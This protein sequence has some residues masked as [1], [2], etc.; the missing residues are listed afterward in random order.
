MAVDSKR[1][2]KNT[3]VLYLRMIITLMVGLF[4][5][6][7]TLQTLGISDYVVYNVVGGFV[8]IL[9]YIN[10]VFIDADQR[11]ITF[12]LGEGNKD[13]LKRVFSTSV[14]TQVVYVVILIIVSE[15][16]GLWFVNHKLVI[17]PERIVAANWVYHCSIGSLLLTVL[18]I[19]YRACIVAHERMGIYAYISIVEIILKLV[20]VYLLVVIPA[21][22]LIVYALLHLFV[23]FLIPVWFHI[24]CIKH[25][26]ECKLRFAFDKK[27]FKEMFSFSGWVLIGNLGFSFKDQFSNIMMNM[28][29]GPVVNAARGVSMQ[30]NGM[31]SNFVNNFL[32]ALSPQITKQYAIG[33]YAG[34][35][36]LVYQG[37][38]FAFYMMMVIGVPII[39]NIDILLKLWLGVVPEFTNT[40]ILITIV[41][42]MY[43]AMSKPLTTA[44]Q[45]TGDIKWF[46]I[47]VAIIMVLELPIAYVL[48]KMGSAP[49]W[50][51][52]PAIFRNIAGVLFRLYLLC[53]ENNE[54]QYGDYVLTVM[55]KSTVLLIIAFVLSYVVKMYMAGGIIG[56]LTSLVV[57]LGITMTTVYLLGMSRSEQQQIIRYAKNIIRK[58]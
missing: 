25:F 9:S 45:A 20:I 40:F 13:K 53:R 12:S 19:P 46:Q 3:F 14:F 8:A 28:F 30:V 4:T 33:D 31:V 56:L 6:R 34:S 24:Y 49:Y 55:L 26:E 1:I 38:R 47:G 27:V 36:N 15:T 44:I 32:L 41:S 48:L 39:I 11:F 50:A 42:S 58:K 21:D 5:S 57:A 2:A 7:I 52:L 10:S 18:N 51:M 17:S 54:F 43:Y 35:K 29:L 22:K 16:I 23:S 37:S